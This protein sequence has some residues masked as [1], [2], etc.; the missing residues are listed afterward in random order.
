LVVAGSDSESVFSEEYLKVCEGA[1]R[2]GSRVSRPGGRVTTQTDSE[3]NFERR[4]A[5]LLGQVLLVSVCDI[6]L[7]KTLPPYDLLFGMEISP[8][9]V[10]PFFQGRRIHFLK[11]CVYVVDPGNQIR[12]KFTVADR[13]RFKLVERNV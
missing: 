4:L 1:F 5:L 12:R 10:Q 7:R 11:C 2:E 9:V 13:T 6:A 8:E 3:E